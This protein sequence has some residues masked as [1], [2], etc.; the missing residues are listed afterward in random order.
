M[1]KKVF[2]LPLSIFF[3]LIC[4]FIRDDSGI[5]MIVE[6][7]DKWRNSYPQEK[8]YLHL[9]KSL[10]LI[11]DTLYCKAYIADADRNKPTSISKIVYVDVTDNDNKVLKTLVLPVTDGIAWGSFAVNHL[12]HEGSY[13]I[14]AYTNWMRNFDECFFF[15]KKITIT[16]ISNKKPSGR[17][18]ASVRSQGYHKTY[19]FPEGGQMVVDLSARI[20]FKAIGSNGLGIN[21]SGKVTDE[22]GLQTLAFK[23]GFAGMGSYKFTPLPQHTYKATVKYEDGFEE[24]VPL[25]PA[26]ATGYTLATDN[27]NRETI[28]INVTAKG[29]PDDVILIG[30]SNNK[31][32]YSTNLKLINGAINTTISKKKFPTGIAQFT[33]FTDKA[34]PV[35]ERLLFINHN[36]QLNIQ[37]SL[38]KSSSSKR[39][40]VRLWLHVTNNLEEAITGSFSI[41]V[42]DGNTVP[43]DKM[44]EQNITTN[45]LLTSDIKGYVE[46]PNYYFTNID[47]N[48]IRDLDNLLLTHGW[49]RFK[50]KEIL[51][52]Q[53]PSLLYPAEKSLAIDGKVMSE[54]GKPAPGAAVTLL[55]KNG[56]GFMLTTQTDDAGDFVF[57]KLNPADDAQFLIQAAAKNGNKNVTIT[58]NAFSPPSNNCDGLTNIMAV[59]D[60]GLEAYKL[61]N[62][63]RWEDKKKFGLVAEDVHMLKGVTVRTAKLTK[64]QEAVAPSY[65]LNGPGNADQ[66]LTYD[67]IPNCHDLLQCLQGKIIGVHFK[68]VVAPGGGII[69]KAYSAIGQNSPMLIVLDGM[70]MSSLSDIQAKDVQSIEVLRSGNYLSSYGMRAAG[71]VLVITTRK[72]GLDYDHLDDN[73]K[74]GEGMLFTKLSGYTTSREFYSPDYSALANNSAMHDLRSTIYWQPNLVTDDDGNA[75]IEWYNADVTGKYNISIEG[76]S[77]DGRIGNTFLSYEVK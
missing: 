41:A 65:N 10:F 67:D 11:G 30:Q 24:T 73:K 18:L 60:S 12:W 7:L 64:V 9:N 27:M 35:A 5:E 39:E 62:E 19:F 29:V 48:K 47:S 52:N 56:S 44:N 63:N 72:G 70:D 20:A 3:I 61:A 13:Q 36:D 46:N 22:N 58:I 43:F 2:F 40:K 28:S 16:G 53:H 6:K 45:L 38:D 68:S 54:N 71:G 8:V 17:P 69:T 74:A 15:N 14:R 23:S 21:V 49:R 59:K 75:V 33:L 77:N 76:I 42:T 55:S 34:V 31:I 51:A 1:P 32:Q 26:E 50:W 57:D 4:A 25:P 66:I 37:A